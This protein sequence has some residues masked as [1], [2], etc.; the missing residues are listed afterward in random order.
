MWPLPS[1]PCLTN[2]SPARPSSLAFPSPSQILSLLQKCL[3]ACPHV[4]VRP[5]SAQTAPFSLLLERIN[6]LQRTGQ[7]TLI[8]SIWKKAI[9]GKTIS[10]QSPVLQID[11]FI[12]TRVAH[13]AAGTR[14]CKRFVQLCVYGN[15]PLGLLCSCNSCWAIQTL[16][17]KEF[18]FG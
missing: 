5:R 3:A 14:R 13:S 15:S 8:Q 1:L 2:C 4:L 6:T 7:F 17:F 9:S 12:V 11:A 16:L 10:F 18:Q